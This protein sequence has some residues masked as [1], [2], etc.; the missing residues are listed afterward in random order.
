VVLLGSFEAFSSITDSPN[1]TFT[2]RDG[3]SFVEK[4]LTRFGA[5]TAALVLAQAIVY[6]LDTVK[7]RM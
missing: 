1:S 4:Y 2:R 3:R 6:P 5:G 7:R